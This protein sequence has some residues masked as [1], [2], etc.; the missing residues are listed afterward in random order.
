MPLV[1]HDT[2]KRAKVPFAPLAPPE[3]RMYNCGPTVYSPAHIGNFRSFLLGDVLRRWLEASG[4]RVTQVMNVTD[5]GHARDDDPDFGEDKLDAAA[6][7]EKL[8]PWQV[9][10]KYTAL[11][12]EDL[13]ALGLQRPH[14]QPRATQFIPQMIAI[15][16]RLV[17][18]GHAYVS[19]HDVYYSVPSF[20]AYGRLSGNTGDDL[21]AGARVE[22]R[23]AK[24]DPRD[25]ALWKS[26][27][28]HL[29]Q[30]DSPWGR[31]FPGWHIECSAMSRA[32]LGEGT[33]DVHTGGE[34]N[35][36]PHH[37]CEIAQSEGA[38]GV[39][40]V[41]HWLHA[42]FL[43][44]EGAKMSKSLGNLYTVGQLEQM[45][46]PPV[47]VRFALLRSHYRQV[48]NFTF[49]G[50]RQA[51][52]DVRRLRLFAAGMQEAA[53]G[54]A[55]PETAPEFVAQAVARFDAGMD[56][57]LNVSAAL[58]GAF[59][60]LNEANRLRARG[61]D[62]AAAL[63]AL[64]RMDRVLGVLEREPA[65]LD[66]QVEELIAR[67]NAA[68]AARDFAAADALRAQLAELGIELLDGKDGV[69]WR[70]AVKA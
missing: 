57:D 55:A 64:R 20:P 10:E 18:S 33:L 27:P 45:G 13:D 62:A 63:A 29:M 41:R 51:A 52:S 61:A 12:L 56:D 4:F 39:P 50:L 25:F 35:I 53:A 58:D 43:Q 19:G 54:A 3:V 67:R 60:L 59:T 1:L 17:A 40:F 66:A 49:D 5:V 11:F 24:R 32:C 2:L 28:H 65:T 22:V 42:R 16:E 14:H 38:F 23:E 46:H 15:I 34:D 70:R 48:L 30:W 7:K 68:R 21:L 31:G 9:A 36:F 69:K 6:R 8:D 37:E 44:V 47:A 26:D